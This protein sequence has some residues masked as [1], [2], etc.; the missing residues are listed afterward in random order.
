MFYFLFFVCF[1]SKLHITAKSFCSCDLTLLF[2]RNP[3][4][5]GDRPFPSYTKSTKRTTTTT[6]PTTTSSTTTATTTSITSAATTKPIS[7]LEY[8]G[9]AYRSNRGYQNPSNTNAPATTTKTAATTKPMSYL[10]HR[11]LAYRNMGY[12]NY[13]NTNI[14]ESTTTTTP[15][16]TTTIITTPGYSI[17]SKILTFKIFFLKDIFTF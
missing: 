16:T 2:F 12:Q 7:Y 4:C 6:T 1:D 8:R 14:P 15:R 10:E 13:R 9:L 5:V 17:E 11:G 3:F